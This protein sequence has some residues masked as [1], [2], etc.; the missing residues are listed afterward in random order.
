MVA[1]TKQKQRGKVT[2]NRK[3]L[4]LIGCEG[5]NKTEKNYFTE[6]NR[7]QKK[8]MI[9]PASG[10]STDPKGIVEDTV[11]SMGKFEEEDLAFCLFDSD[12]DKQKQPQIDQAVALAKKNGIEV[13][14]SVPCF[15]IWFLQHFQYST[16]SLTSN[17]T[18]DKLKKFIPEYEKSENVFLQLE[19]SMETAV[20]HAERLER[21]HNELGVQSK[22]LERNPSTE[23]Y[24]LV[25]LLKKE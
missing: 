3:T 9:K 16:G 14:L 1:R 7:T 10:N 21:Y 6:F 2:K 20:E 5:K 12:T 11:V 8:Y 4:I 24:K 18:I 15:E 19:E 17:Q 25:K 23:A 13:L 22:S